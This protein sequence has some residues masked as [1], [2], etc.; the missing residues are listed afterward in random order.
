MRYITQLRKD[1][2]LQVFVV[3]DIQFFVN[4]KPLLY[5]G[6]L[7]IS[8]SPLLIKSESTESRI[9]LQFLRRN[10]AWD[11][12]MNRQPSIPR[13]Y[14]TDKNRGFLKLMAIQM[15]TIAI[16]NIKNYLKQINTIPMTGII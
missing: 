10:T 2:K 6:D 13:S 15:E 5:F 11:E 16:Y 14:S 3:T 1:G 12:F 4:S 9:Y 8:L 7:A